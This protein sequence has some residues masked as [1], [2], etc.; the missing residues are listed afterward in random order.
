[1]TL[2]L[3]DYSVC[4]ALSWQNCVEHY[5]KAS[6][7]SWSTSW[8]KKLGH[9]FI[10]TLELL[11]VISQVASLIEYC[12]VGNV[13]L[14]FGNVSSE[15]NKPRIIIVN[16]GNEHKFRRAL[17]N[18][19]NH[20]VISVGTE[21]L[22][23]S[24]EF[25]P[26][27]DLLIFIPSKNPGLERFRN[28]MEGDGGYSHVKDKVLAFKNIAV[29]YIQRS[30]ESGITKELTRM[31]EL[32]LGK[33][34]ANGFAEGRVLKCKVLPTDH[35]YSLNWESKVVRKIQKLFANTPSKP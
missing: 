35:W 26:E 15:K 5:K 14:N 25:D 23:K 30:S 13:K 27:K 29:V 20:K 34:G 21:S 10:A 6:E 11:P 18:K 8:S 17:E 31:L 9:G 1:M 16:G 2:R 12:V 7:G 28:F 3:D 22:G 19:T 32:Q 24:N 4:K 33:N